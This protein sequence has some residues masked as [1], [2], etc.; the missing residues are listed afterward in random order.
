MTVLVVP[1]PT[2]ILYY[3]LNCGRAI[4]C[5]VVLHWDFHIS[6]MSND[7]EYVFTRDIGHLST[8]FCKMPV[9]DFCTTP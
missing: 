5:S 1:N 4:E 3:L 9:Q 2:K 6:L 8:F 7:V